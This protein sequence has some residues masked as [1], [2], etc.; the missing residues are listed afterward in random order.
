M[1][2]A[3]PAVGDVNPRTIKPEHFLSL[4]VKTGQATG[5]ISAIESAISVTNRGRMIKGRRAFWKKMASM[6]YC[7]RNADPSLVFA[8]SAPEPRK[9]IW[10]RRVAA[11]AVCT[12]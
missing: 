1:E 6:R 5:L 3:R 4:D 2:V 10:K 8:N 7:D 9:G 11:C 12:A